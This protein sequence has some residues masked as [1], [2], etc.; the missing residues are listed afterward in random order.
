MKSYTLLLIISIHVCFQI[1]MS[2]QWVLIIVTGTT[3][4]RIQ[5]AVSHADVQRDSCSI[6]V[7]ALVCIMYK[8]EGRRR[9]RWE[10]REGGGKEG[11][12][13]REGR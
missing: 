4:V 8:R 3:P 7:F 6:L 5:K 11:W 13:R 1:L 2:V 10:R 9:R 12:E